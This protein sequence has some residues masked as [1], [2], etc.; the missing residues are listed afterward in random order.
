MLSVPRLPVL[1][2][3]VVLSLAVLLPGRAAPPGDDAFAGLLDKPAPKIEADFVVATKDGKGAKERT[4]ADL[5]GKVVLVNF[6]A[7]WSPPCVNCLPKWAE[8]QREYEIKNF[9]LV[10]VTI[11]AGDLNK[12]LRLNQSN[13]QVT[14]EDGEMTREQER[15]LLKQFSAIKELNWRLLVVGGED[16]RALLK[17]YHVKNVPQMVLIDRKGVVREVQVGGTPEN[18]KAMQKAIERVCKEK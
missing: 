18:L 16:A 8:W 12:K 14:E 3:L 15:A 1:L 6:L 2:G 11:Y 4:I 7:V 10:G 9:E 13:G 17:A 5:K